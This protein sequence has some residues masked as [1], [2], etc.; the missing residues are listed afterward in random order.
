MDKDRLEEYQAKLATLSSAPDLVQ[1][2]VAACVDRFLSG[3]G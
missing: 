1:D 2:P 3:N